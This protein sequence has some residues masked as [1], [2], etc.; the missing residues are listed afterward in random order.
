MGKP[1]RRD[2][3]INGFAMISL[4]AVVP[5]LILYWMRR[6]IIKKKIATLA[7]VLLV[8]LVGLIASAQGENTSLAAT[9]VLAEQGDSEAQSILGI[10]YATGRGVPQDDVLA[11]KWL[12]LGADQGNAAAQNKLSYMYRSGF[13]VPKDNALAF[14]WLRLS[15]EHGD[16]V[17]Q[18]ILG[19]KY[20]TGDE[21]VQRDLV[22]SYMWF[23]ASAANGN[24]FNAYTR[25]ILAKRML[26]EQ[27]SEAQILSREFI[28]A[29]K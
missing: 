23:N 20:S 29:T 10:R 19:I 1:L 2:G 24:R 28:H 14:K 13:G 27:I 6:G 8:A 26:P 15:A 21:N 5:T 16:S 3:L 22:K 25:D 18:Y 12:R 9:R 11:V 17:A 4:L 7:L